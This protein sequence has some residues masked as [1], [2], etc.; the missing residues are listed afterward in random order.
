[1]PSGSA[2]ATGRAASVSERA[3]I[4][5]TNRIRNAV[6]R[7]AREDPALAHHLRTTI[8]TGRLCSYQPGPEPSVSWTL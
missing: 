6:E 1:A 8:R 7:I 3:R 2:A 5:L 4:S